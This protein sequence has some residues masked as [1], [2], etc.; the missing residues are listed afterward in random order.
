MT[1]TLRSS[2]TVAPTAFEL[3]AMD[4]KAHRHCMGCNGCLLDPSHIVQSF[5]AWCVGCRDRIKKTT[6]PGI[7]LPWEQS[8][9]VDFSERAKPVPC[10]YCDGSGRN[11]AYTAEGWVPCAWCDGRKVEYR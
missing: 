9:G 8:G 4:H 2:E 3:F 11:P 5:L 7:P 1:D 10:T 6:A